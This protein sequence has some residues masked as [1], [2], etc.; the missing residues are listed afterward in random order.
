LQL[1]NIN[2]ELATQALIAEKL[3]ANSLREM[4]LKRGCR[5]ARTELV[6][7][8]SKLRQGRRELSDRVHQEEIRL[9]EFQMQLKTLRERIEEE[10]QLSLEQVVSSGASAVRLYWQQEAEPENGHKE[11]TAEIDP[12]SKDA[13]LVDDEPIED[14]DSEEIVSGEETESEELE[15]SNSEQQS[16]HSADEP[17]LGN[18]EFIELYEQIREEIESR[19]SKLRQRLKTMGSINTESLDQLDS[20]ET[21]FAH[22]SMQLEDLTQA[23][24]ALEDIIRRINTESRRMFLETYNS[25]RENFQDLFRKL[26]GGGNGDII[27]EDP[28]D[29]LECG[30]EIVARPPGKELRSISLLSGGE[31]TMTAVALLMAI[32]RSKPSPFCILDEVDAALDEANIGR[33]I[34]VVKEFQSETQFIMITHRKPSMTVTDRLFGVTMEESGVSKRLTVQFDDIKENGEFDTDAG[35]N[36]RAA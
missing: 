15:P 10:Y 36:R 3:E 4:R 17:V 21:R 23:K 26:F 7:Q 24:N 16:D 25:I 29:P 20:L 14:F 32:F 5:D 12:D 27:L 6:E 2:S 22:L 34:N 30:I 1:L 13:S 28:D 8:E 11:S 9:Q 31:K 35:Q 19:V 33:F 18:A